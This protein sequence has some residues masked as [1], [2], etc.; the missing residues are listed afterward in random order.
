[1]SG[2][3]GAEQKLGLWSATSL[4]VANMVGIGPFITIPAFLA[5][6]Q[7]PHAIIAWVL[8]AV[9][10]I[11]DGLVWSELGAAFPGSGGSY[12]FLRQIYSGT[13]LGRLLPFLFVWQFLISGAL[14]MASGYIGALQYAEY[15]WPGL[16]EWTWPGGSRWVAAGATILVAGLLCRPIHQ[17]AWLSVILAAGTALT[18][19]TVIA[20]GLANA[21]P[22]LL[23]IPPHAF[24]LNREWAG[25]LG[26]AMLIAVYDYLGYYNVCHLGDEVRDP[27]RTIPRA[28]MLSV[29]LVA[30]V[31]LT[32]N[33]SIIMVVP[34]SEAMVSR[35]IAADFMERLFGRSAAVAFTGLILWTSVACVFA[36]TLGY[37]RIPYAAARQGDFFKAFAWQHPTAGYPVWSLVSLTLLTASFCFLDLGVVIEAAVVVRLLVQFLGQTA[38]LWWLHFYRPEVVRPFRMWWSPWPSLIS[39]AGWCYLLGTTRPHVL[40]LA[41]GVLVLGLGVFVIRG[42][43]AASESAASNGPNTQSVEQ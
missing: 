12:H 18:V 32:M 30:I 43:F 17:I 26:A 14:E 37:S 28:V 42:R 8:A 7:G 35:N 31:Y 13:R 16:R 24:L 3:Q 41:V 4:N 34:W 33:L 25:G 21:R 9:V 22:E 11:C 20:A 38:G 36:L 23:A 5:A 29:V 6:M 1:M 39:A 27:V 15:V 10:V 2:E 19:L 40:G